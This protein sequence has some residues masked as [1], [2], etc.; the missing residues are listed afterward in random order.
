MYSS[1][2]PSLQ[3]KILCVPLKLYTNH[4]S[5]SF[6]LQDLLR[7]F[8]ASQLQLA[9]S[10]RS[11]L[12]RNVILV[13]SREYH[14]VKK[15]CN[16][17]KLTSPYI[18]FLCTAKHHQYQSIFYISSHALHYFHDVENRS[19]LGEWSQMNMINEAAPPLGNQAIVF[20]TSKTQ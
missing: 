19:K 13:Y 3:Y 10:Q 6:H 17:L 1:F 20:S 5:L 2:Q 4:L 7:S 14:G 8:L 15:G 16:V 11:Q 9:L 12:S 18:I